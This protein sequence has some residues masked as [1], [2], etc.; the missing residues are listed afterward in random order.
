MFLSL[1]K[2]PSPQ[3]MLRA[4]K[5]EVTQTVPFWLMRQAGRY[6]P[7]YRDLRLK[8]GSFL[9][10]CFNPEW[11]AEVTLQPL[12]RFDMDAAIIFSDILVIPYAFGQKLDFV[13]KEG[14]K[15]D[16]IQEKA[17]FERLSFDQLHEKLAPVYEALK[18]VRGKLA[19]EKTL[20]G[21]AGAPW[22]VACYMVEG[23]GG[24]EFPLTRKMAME[25]PEEFQILIDKLTAATTEYLLAQIDAGADALQL[26]DSWS[27]LLPEPFFTRFVTA[28]AK[29]IAAAIER[30]HKGFP[31]IGFP[32]GCGDKYPAYVRQTGIR[33]VAL[34]Q[35]V[36]LI[37]AREAL[38]PKICIQG[39]LD[40]MALISG[41]KRLDDEA[42]LILEA[43]RNHP[44]VFN[45]GHGILKETPPEHVAQ[46]AQIIKEFKRA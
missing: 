12:R 2:K 45:L 1:L 35:H 21:F 36:P 26:F 3:P 27:G 25:T 5:G 23:E 33:A 11:A 42:N 39:N 16:P 19:P 29:K 7:E 30:R 28:P 8:A 37:W 22:T 18:I 10:L 4:L 34:D 44:F 13:E 41:G 24:G 40:P 6:L 32:R 17:E 38:G 14:P 31:L 43:C 46:L 9:D 15:L 20:I